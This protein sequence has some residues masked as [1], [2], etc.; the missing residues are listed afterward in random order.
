MAFHFVGSGLRIEFM[1]KFEKLKQ[2]WEFH[3]AYSRGESFVTPAFV[4]YACKGKKDTVRL[5]ITAGKKIG[6]AVKRNRAKRVIS[7]A[8][9]SCLKNVAAGHDY[10]IVARVKILSYKSDR[11]ADLLK[12]QFKSAELWVE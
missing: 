9:G 10:V 3:R 11:V 1:K 6:C 4:L 12:K 2:N 5:G 8:F 7:A